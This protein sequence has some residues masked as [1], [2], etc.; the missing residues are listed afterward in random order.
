MTR[1]VDAFKLIDGVVI[2]G[3][4][5]LSALM[6]RPSLINLD[7]AGKNACSTP[8]SIDNIL[9]LDIRTVLRTGGHALLGRLVQ[10]KARGALLIAM[11]WNWSRRISCY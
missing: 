5:S 9:K 11:Q 2:D 3:I 8:N 10:Q 1:F 7:F 6:S 4:E